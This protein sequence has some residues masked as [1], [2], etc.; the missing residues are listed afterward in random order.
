MGGV[1]SPKIGGEGD[2]FEFQRPLKLKPFYKDPIDNRQFGGQKSDE[3]RAR[4]LN[5]S[6]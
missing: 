1:K 2:N 5:G 3:G 4:H 6:L